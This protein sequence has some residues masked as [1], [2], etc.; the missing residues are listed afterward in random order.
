MNFTGPLASFSTFVSMVVCFVER[1][2]IA[3]SKQSC[4]TYH[5]VPFRIGVSNKKEG[6]D[7]VQEVSVTVEANPGAIASEMTNNPSLGLERRLTP[8]AE[9]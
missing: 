4:N 6:V 7:I 3:R 1:S 8:H 9:G 2:V 5:Q